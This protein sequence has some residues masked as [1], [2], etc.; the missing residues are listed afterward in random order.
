MKLRTL[1]FITQ[2]FVPMLVLAQYKPVE[3]AS[4][5]TFNIKNLGFNVDGSFK[6]FDGAINFDPQNLAAS[7]FN[8]TIDANTVNTDNNL[9]DSHVRDE[10]FEVKTY[11]RIRLTSTKI[12]GKNGNYVFTGMLT[13]KSTTKPISFPFTA[14]WVNDAYVFK[15]SFKIKRKDF[16]VGG[17]ST[18]SDELE[19]HLNVTAK[20]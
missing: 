1:L 5:L 11:P 12:V 3:Q 6:G 18:V 8:V 9:R 4:T 17:T 2:L 10:F 14:D 20:K 19:V 15:G 7:N 16:G 13:M